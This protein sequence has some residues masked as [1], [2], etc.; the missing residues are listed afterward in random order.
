MSVCSPWIAAL[1]LRLRPERG[2][3]FE[4]A[5]TRLIRA[6]A[7]AKREEARRNEVQRLEA[8]R[9]KGRT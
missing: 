3:V 1:Y 5:V 7:E 9:A 6:R 2:A 4:E 8:A